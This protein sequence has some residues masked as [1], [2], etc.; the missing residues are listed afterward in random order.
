MA[1]LFEGCMFW[2]ILCDIWWVCFFFP[3]QNICNKTKKSKPTSWSCPL[4]CNLSFICLLAWKISLLLF[5]LEVPLTNLG[6]R[7]A[8]CFQFLYMKQK[9]SRYNWSS[10]TSLR[11]VCN[12]V[13]GS[14]QP[15]VCSSPAKKLCP[16]EG[17]A[18]VGGCR[19]Q[20]YGLILTFLPFLSSAMPFMIHGII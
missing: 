20:V 9:E 13:V 11:T 4:H 3:I 2:H 15:L 8:A 14:Q 19:S 1:V 18:V 17:Q 16:R 10:P 5:S 7:V 6:L 12:T